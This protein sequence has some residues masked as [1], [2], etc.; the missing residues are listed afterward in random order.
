MSDEDRYDRRRVLGLA[1]MGMTAARLGLASP[2][3]PA[4]EDKAT[5]TS[6][7]EIRHVEAGVLDVGY[8]EAGPAD[9]RAVI[10]LHGWPYDIHSFVDVA[11]LLASKGYRVIVPYL[12]GYGPT[13]FRS[14][15]T[16][17]NGQPV[18]A[19]VRRR[20]PSRRPR[21]PEAD[22]RG[23]RLGRPHGQRRRG[24]LAG[25]LQGDGLRERLS[26]RQPG[27][28]PA[29]AAAGGGAPVVVPVLLRDGTR[30]R[31]LRKYRR[32]FSRLIWKIASPKWRFDAAT[33]DRTAA[34]FD[35]PDHVAIVIHNY[36]FRLG[37]AEG[38]SK[39][40]DL[41][42]R[43]AEF[44]IITVPTITLEGDA[45]GAPHPEPASYAEKFSGRYAHR[46]L[47]GGI[48]HNLPQEAP[49]DFAQAIVDVDGY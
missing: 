13:R 6:L 19:G 11:P 31:R 32:D 26:D 30:P 27:S 34:A 8:A 46:S 25:P 23:L 9:G 49:A 7:G 44:P 33:F 48:G 42:R 14:S 37:L 18:G 17:R 45:N 5:H 2:G 24:A 15:D 10:L 36:R 41:E 28:R 47:T 38:E 12:R 22:P 39:Y 43:L 21:D 29:A 4:G 1:A 20:R 16:A 3:K 35:N 40:D